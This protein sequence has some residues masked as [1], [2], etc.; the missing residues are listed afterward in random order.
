[1]H[2]LKIRCGIR[3]NNSYVV[4]DPETTEGLIIDAPDEPDKILENITGVKVKAIL[5]THTHADQLMGLDRL[6]SYTEAPVWVNIFDAMVFNYFTPT[7]SYRPEEAFHDGSTLA[8]GHLKL[9]AIHTPGHTPGA[10][11]YLIGNHLF[12]GD[13]LLANGPG[14]TMNSEAYQQSIQS[15][16]NKLFLLP[17][18]TIV[19]PAQGEDIRLGT[20]KEEYRAF[21]SQIRP[22]DLYGNVT[23]QIN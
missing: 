22:T 17:D 3:E 20:S 2:V 13:T 12:S 14:Y 4:V 23:W 16:V 8:V 7:N 9:K 10:S 19:H 21:H 1:M 11:C 18:N 5:I 15:I 6:R